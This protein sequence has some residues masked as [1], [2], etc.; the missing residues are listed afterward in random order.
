MDFALS[1]L[2]VLG[3]YVLR[4]AAPRAVDFALSG[5]N[6]LGG[7]VLQGVVAPCC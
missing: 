1:G 3:D 4:G 7:N 6:V 5:L 2:N